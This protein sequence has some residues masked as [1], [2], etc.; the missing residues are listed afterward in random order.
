MRSSLASISG[1]TRRGVE[2]SPYLRGQFKGLKTAGLKVPT[3][4][5]LKNLPIS[6]ILSTLSLDKLRIKVKPKLDK[7]QKVIHLL[8]K[9]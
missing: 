7:G 8:T 1:N 9:V 4:A 2:L 5:R 3:I 6:T